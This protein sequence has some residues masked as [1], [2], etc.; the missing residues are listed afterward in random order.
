[1]N[2]MIM[3]IIVFG[4]YTLFSLLLISC[5]KMNKIVSNSTYYENN[6]MNGKILPPEYR[7]AIYEYGFNKGKPYQLK[8][9]DYDIIKELLKA[10]IIEYNSNNK[11]LLPGV[12]I[13]KYMDM[14]AYLTM[15]NDIGDKIV[16]VICCGVGEDLI[17]DSNLDK[18]D[19]HNF[20]AL[21]NITK[22]EYSEFKVKWY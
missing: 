7:K 8:V 15:I 9:D 2:K 1:M 16:F 5:E 20:Q 12:D 3:I 14:A 13:K 11:E 6:E 21:L 22:R 4:G 18:I 17:K 19:D 10:A